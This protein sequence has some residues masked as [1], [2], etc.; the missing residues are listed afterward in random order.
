MTRRAADE[1]V[2]V[3]RDV[4]NRAIRTLE[5]GFNME[6][7]DTVRRSL[8]LSA[9]TASPAPAHAEAG[10]ETPIDMVLFCPRCGEQHIDAPDERTPDWTN[11]PHKSHLCH[12]CGCI[13]RPADVPTNGVAAI[14]TKGKNDTP[15]TATLR[16]AAAEMEKALEDAR[17][18]LAD[19]AACGDNCPVCRAYSEAGAQACADALATFISSKAHP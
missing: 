6:D 15:L 8:V 7:I 11:P 1:W 18:W 14:R 16:S 3:P 9:R 12:A 13:W 5:N 4:F 17:G 19:N 10:E 2:T